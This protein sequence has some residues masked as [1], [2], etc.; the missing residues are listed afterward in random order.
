MDWGLET[1]AVPC[2]LVRELLADGT[3]PLHLRL[4]LQRLLDAQHKK[5][6]P[7]I[8]DVEE[9]DR[10]VASQAAPEPPSPLTLAA[11]GPMLALALQWLELPDVLAARAVSSCCLQW[12]SHSACEPLGAVSVAHRRIK[13]RLWIECVAAANKGSKDET[14]YESRVRQ[15]ADDALRRRM[16]VEMT[17]ARTE[18]E[19]QIRNFQAEVD[20][21]MEQQAVRVHAI[22]EERVQQQ[23]HTMLASEMEKVRMLVEERVQARVRAVVQREVHQTVYD[24]QV[25]TGVLEQENE[26][27]RRALTEHL[28]HADLC[29][30]A[31]VWALSPG[32]T[33]LF[34]HTVRMFWSCRRRFTRFSA[35]ALGVPVHQNRERLQQRLEMLYE[36]SKGQGSATSAP[37]P[38]TAEVPQSVQDLA[39]RLSNAKPA[40]DRED[41]W[42]ELTFRPPQRQGPRLESLDS[43]EVEASESEEDDAPWSEQAQAETEEL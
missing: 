27:L 3:C 24:M 26:H 42:P 8:T 38:P 39:W 29:C 15:L 16:E 7:E 32:S 11:L 22:V 1:V 23:L 17:Q 14:V 20:R 33:G 4:Q 43:S 13:S 10:A 35:R 36:R 19:R 9:V 25:R 18:M 6:E 37:S 40:A 41:W 31:L 28:E 21:R 12:A 30:R 5:A 34:A 2:T